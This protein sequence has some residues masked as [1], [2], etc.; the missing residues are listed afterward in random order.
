MV[1]LARFLK[2]LSAFVILV[3][4]SPLHADVLPRIAS[5]TLQPKT[6]TIDATE[7]VMKDPDGTEIRSY[8][9]VAAQNGIFEFNDPVP[10]GAMIYSIAVYFRTLATCTPSNLI[11]VDLNRYLPGVNPAD[12]LL[13]IIP[14]QGSTTSCQIARFTDSFGGSRHLLTP[15]VMPYV[16]GGVNT[17]YVQELGPGCP[18]TRIDKVQID[19]SYYVEAPLISFDLSAGSDIKQRTVLMQK[20]RSDDDYISDFQKA[21]QPTPY[22]G[23]D[24]H[25]VITGHA[26]NPDG[27]PYANQTI[28][29]RTIDPPDLADYV[30]AGE[31]HRFDNF[32]G[33]HSFV[34]DVILYPYNWD[35]VATDQ[36]GAF[37]AT[38]GTEWQWAGNNQQ[39]EASA[40]YLPYDDTRDRCTPALM[41]YTS[42]VIT[43]WR[44]IYVENDHMFRSG[45]FLTLNA[46]VGDTHIAVSDGAPF[47]NASHRH[48]LPVLFIHAPTFPGDTYYKELHLVVGVAGSR[49]EPVI[50]LAQGET[51][52]ARFVAVGS[53]EFQDLF[54]GDAVGVY[55]G[56]GDVFPSNF[57]LAKPLFA[58]MFTDVQ[59]VPSTANAGDLVPYADCR[60]ETYCGEV[61]ARWFDNRNG[62]DAMPNHVHIVNAAQYG[63]ST[64]GGTLLHRSV[65]LQPLNEYT[66]APVV[67]TYNAVIEANF[68]I[69]GATL[70]LPEVISHELVHTFDVNQP[71]NIGYTGHCASMAW[72][73]TVRNC[74]LSHNR[75]NAER[76]SGDVTLHNDPW[77]TSEYRRVRRR[78]EPV[79][80]FNQDML[81]PNY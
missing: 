29:L 25:V 9:T 24:N 58:N 52:G 73:S 54:A 2:F 75:T 32:G 57:D 61:A 46:A 7:C 34:G 38:L 56:P 28:Y 48:P 55:R 31:S 14:A 36:N 53:N 4:A 10:P 80:Q 47:Q 78:P 13:G 76:A 62:N 5:V 23:K 65:A 39:V 22:W 68:G 77:A 63:T 21:V 40:V 6:L 27:T 15:L 45:A 8:T 1:K 26:V 16:A 60:T 12:T 51:V 44:R 41:C 72:N 64:I 50:H 3:C 11:Q 70:V 59:M 43:A 37:K 33:V 19:V 79:P 74:L 66:L 67:F 81:N 69:A 17:L 71:V 42:G 35:L 20:Y 18:D 49:A 30:P